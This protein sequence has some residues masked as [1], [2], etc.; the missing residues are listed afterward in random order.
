MRNL[1]HIHI[2]R[3]HTELSVGRRGSGWGRLNQPR[4]SAAGGV[5]HL[6][7]NL[8]AMLRAASMSVA[9]LAL[10]VIPVPGCLAEVQQASLKVCTITAAG[11]LRLDIIPKYRIL[12]AVLV[13]QYSYLEA[14]QASLKVCTFT[15][16][17]ETEYNTEQYRILVVVVLVQQCQQ[18]AKQQHRMYFEFNT[19][20]IRSTYYVPPFSLEWLSHHSVYSSSTL[21]PPL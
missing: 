21:V 8:A 13:Q 20:I 19:S 2:H 6:A 14:Q 15:A 5:S 11:E 1:P 10:A 9:V 17:G 7:M 3:C 4:D 18:W 16:A 12:V